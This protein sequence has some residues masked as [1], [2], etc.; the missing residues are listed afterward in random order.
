MYTVRS[1]PVNKS[2]QSGLHNKRNGKNIAKGMKQ[3]FLFQ[4][5]HNLN[6]YREIPATVIKRDA[7][8]G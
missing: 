2:I 4:K 7:M 1:N 6:T 5:D 3:G 8:L